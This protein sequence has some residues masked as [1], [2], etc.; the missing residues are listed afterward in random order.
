MMRI[1]I[2]VVSG[3]RA[4]PALSVNNAGAGKVHGHADKH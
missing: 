4:G 1:A 3:A 2:S